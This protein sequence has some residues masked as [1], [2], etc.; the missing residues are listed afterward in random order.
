MHGE[1]G[2][3]PVAIDSPT[4][5]RCEK[6]WLHVK[7]HEFIYNWHP[8]TIG[9]IEDNKFK[10]TRKIE[11]P[12]LFS[13]FRGSAVTEMNDHILALVHFCEYS[14]L[15]N[16]YH[17]FVKLEKD[18]YRVIGISL[19]F[20][21]KNPGIEYCLSIHNSDCFATFNDANPSRLTIDFSAVEWVNV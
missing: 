10:V 11:T 4:N 14:K 13:L 12:P 20:I 6:N 2:C 3:N 21:F 19:P 8:L 1:Y 7:N 17:C 15:R 9:I 5:A 18:T 16:Y